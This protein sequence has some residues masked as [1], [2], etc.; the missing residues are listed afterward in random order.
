MNLLETCICYNKTKE[1]ITSQKL[2]SQDFWRVANS[3]LNKGKS[4]I[5]PLFNGSE[6]L[7]SASDKAK[8]FPEK[9]SVNSSISLPVFPSRTNLKLH[10]ISETPKMVRKVV[11]NLD[12]SKASGPN[13]IPVVVLKNCEPEL[14]YVLAELFNKCLKES[15]FP[16]CWKVSSVVPVV[17]NVGEWS[18]AKNY[19]TVSLLSVVSSLWKTCK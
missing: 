9:F 5:P 7:S 11:M 8:L 16:D 13:C 10:K 2:G 1:P 19:G 3:V 4:A 6:V 18:T 12:L 14:S 15:S 17:K